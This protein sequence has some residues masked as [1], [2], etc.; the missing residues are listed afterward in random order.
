[1][2]ALSASPTRGLSVG[3]YINCADN[4]GTKIFQIISVRSYKGKRRT[5]PRVGIA[6][7]VKCRVYKGNEKVRHE[8]FDVVI[9]RHK[10][11]WR[12]ADG[13][14]VSF[15]DNAGVVVDDKFIPKGTIIKGAIARE[16]VDRFPA[17]GK[18][19]SVVV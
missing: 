5:K 1:M 18:T 15:E 17:I 2:K 9:V 12:R 4:T 13:M 14:R 8:L 10:K 11:E 6:G 7:V 16:V 3:S 19:A